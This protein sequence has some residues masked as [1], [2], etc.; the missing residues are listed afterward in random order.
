[1]PRSRRCAARSA[2]GL[3]ALQTLLGGHPGQVARIARPTPP[4]TAPVAPVLVDLVLHLDRHLVELLAR[5][6][7]WIYAILFAIIFAETGLVVTPFLPGDSLL[8][9]VR[10]AGRGRHERHAAA[11]RGSL[12]LLALAA[13][14]G[15]S[16]QLQHRARTRAA[17][18]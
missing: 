12:L 4:P 17:R 3:L 6:G 13:I 15:N 10:R 8:F 7:L 18:L 11:A 2:G 16:R 1:M 5:Y 9:G 14:A